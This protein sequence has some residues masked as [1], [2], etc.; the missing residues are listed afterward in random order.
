M[1]QKLKV[2]DKLVSTSKRYAEVISIHTNDETMETV[3]TIKEVGLNHMRR[4]SAALPSDWR[5]FC[6]A[7]CKNCDILKSSP[8]F[9]YV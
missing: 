1:T 9:R 5:I 7:S 6:Q 3:A 2:G 4:I 8:C